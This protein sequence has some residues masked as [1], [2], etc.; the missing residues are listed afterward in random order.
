MKRVGLNR[1]GYFGER[2][3]VHQLL[4]LLRERASDRGWR[5]ETIAPEPAPGLWALVRGTESAPRK[6]YIS[7]G[8]HGDEPAGLLAAARLVDADFWPEEVGV[9]LCPCLNPSGFPLNRRE[10]SHGLDLNRQYLH[11]E[12]PETR[13]HIDWLDRQPR[14]DLAVCLHEDWEANGF[15]LYELA[16]TLAEGWAEHLIERAGCHVPIDLAEEIEG[17]PAS[18]GIIRPST[19][20]LSRPQWP[21]AFYLFSRKT[22]LCYTLEAPS[23]FELAARVNALLG[24]VQGLVEKWACTPAVLPST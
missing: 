11:R 14:F 2:V 4:G 5:V 6:I 15:Y 17:R 18:R 20:P 7:A 21:E 16:E 24:A 23:D 1:G 8:I 19:D 12:A 13:A 22:S 3:D 10:A 9:W